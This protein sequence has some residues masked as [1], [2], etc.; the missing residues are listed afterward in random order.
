ME[1][2][3]A[4]G[5][6]AGFVRKNFRILLQVCAFLAWSGPVGSAKE[7]EKFFS[8]PLEQYGAARKETE[9]VSDSPLERSGAVQ[10]TEIFRK[11]F[12]S[13]I[14]AVWSSLFSRHF[15]PLRFR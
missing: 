12:R 14:G 13:T 9:K 1:Q 8:A 10:K 7:T 11:F 6:E 5:A 3:G 15:I 2:Y 4:T